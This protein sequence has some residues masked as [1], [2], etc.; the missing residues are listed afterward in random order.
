MLTY[1]IVK[2]KCVIPNVKVEVEGLFLKMVSTTEHNTSI[3]TAYFLSGLLIHASKI[4]FPPF[5][6]ATLTVYIM[7]TR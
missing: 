2:F 4:W 1:P 5:S 3:L 7:T 6:F